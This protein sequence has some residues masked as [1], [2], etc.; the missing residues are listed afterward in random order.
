MS[1]QI[2]ALDRQL[3]SLARAARHEAAVDPLDTEQALA[4]VTPGAQLARLRPV[5]NPGPT[6]RWQPWIAVAAATALIVTGGI[7]LLT[8]GDDQV[9]SVDPTILGPAAS[10]VPA[11][12]PSD[13]VTAPPTAPS[14]T[15]S[16]STSPSSSPRAPVESVL[17]TVRYTDDLP[18]APLV[19][20]G[21]VALEGG[22]QDWL[23]AA[24]GDLGV[25][26]RNGDEQNVH[27][28]GF[29][30]Q[31]RDVPVTDELGA[32]AY[33]PGDML[34]GLRWADPAEGQVTPAV[35]IVAIPLS[36]AESG[37]IVA[38]APASGGAVGW[39]E[40]TPSPL[41]HG[42]TGIVDR[43]RQIDLELM[44]YVDTDELV[45]GVAEQPFAEDSTIVTASHRFVLQIEREPGWTGPFTPPIPA[46]GAAGTVVYPTT[47]GAPL[48]P[49]DFAAGTMPVLM[50][51]DESGEVG[52]YSVPEGW[53]YAT[54][55]IWGT[56]FVRRDGSRL[57]IALLGSATGT[58]P[59][60]TAPPTTTTTPST[61]APTTDPAGPP[62]NDALLDGLYYEGAGIDNACVIDGPCTQVVFDPSGVAVSYDPSTRA[63]TWHGRDGASTPFVLP[64]TRPASL[65]AA[66][67]DRVVYIR[68]ASEDPELDNVAA[69]SAQPGDQWREIRAYPGVLGIG[70]Y[71]VVPSPDG[72]VTVG[73]YGQGLQPESSE[74][75][76][77]WVG[78]DGQP[79]TSPQPLVRIDYYGITVEI[80]DRTW[81]FADPV[82]GAHPS[83]PPI[84]PTF[85][86]G[87]L[88]VFHHGADGTPAV[89]RGWSDGTVDTWY[90]PAEAGPWINVTPEPSGYVLVPHGDAFM[91]AE[92]FPARPSDHWD[93]QRSTDVE[94]GTMTAVGLDEYLDA[95]DPWWETDPIGLANAV[96]GPV[97]SPAERR[98]IE[99]RDDAVVVT[100]ENHL[101]DSVYGTQLTFHL[102]AGEGGTRIDRIDWANTCQPGRGHQDYQ[103]ALCV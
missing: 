58:D 23:A 101:D 21:E 38:D 88:A 43:E 49:G 64:G 78:R 27:V 69:H 51:A 82:D 91:R 76:I 8:R 62:R 89:V 61:T 36:G 97:S 17:S 57:E 81:S 16:T 99:Y 34:Y 35:S 10:T 84:T 60:P 12:S 86:G 83:R 93:G 50:V 41:A 90:P 22:P 45:G 9:R 63:V 42:P 25:A 70:D 13:S 18:V 87:F 54:S 5:A 4:E 53:A 6:R 44:R 72:L 24:I 26:V 71:D 65:L 67:P 74:P 29:D 80:G 30:G 31:R 33:G 75:V 28:L 11:T 1:D 47:L 59:V 100:T 94:A 77:E 48:E 46:V 102:V 3:R 15:V 73:W 14:E 98:T 103:A 20:V 37:R 39:V 40:T 7:W 56:V 19:P 95:N 55:D 32:F 68:V 66:G 2:D 96:A 92:L 79:V 52:W 85:D